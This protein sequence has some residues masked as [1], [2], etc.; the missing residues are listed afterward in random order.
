MSKAGKKMEG[1]VGEKKKGEDGRKRIRQQSTWDNK[2]STLAARW[3]AGW[4]TGHTHSNHAVMAGRRPAAGPL[5]C[6]VLG[7]FAHRAGRPI[8]RCDWSVLLTKFV[9]PRGLA[10]TQPTQKLWSRPRNRQLPHTT[11]PALVKKKKNG[12][13]A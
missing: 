8:Q 13:G 3:L 9:A 12:P 2:Q 10:H 1:E 11:S 7:L 5:G 6:R 4:H